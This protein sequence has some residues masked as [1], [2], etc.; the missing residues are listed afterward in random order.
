MSKLKIN[1]EWIDPGGAQGPELSATWARFQLSVD[2]EPVTR[3]LDSVSKTVRDSVFLPIYP[4][5]EWCA[6]HW[7]FLLNEVETPGRTAEVKYPLRHNMYYAS[8][9]FALPPITFR[10]LGNIIKVDWKP[11][12]LPHHRV[13]FVGEGTKYVDSEEFKN[14]ISD[15]ISSVIHRLIEFNCIETLLQQEWQAI[16]EADPEEREFCEASAA[17]GLDPYSLQRNAEQIILN[18]GDTLPKSLIN[19]FFSAADFPHLREQAENVRQALELSRSNTVDLEPLKLLREKAPAYIEM[20][21]APWVQGYQAARQLRRYLQLNGQ[22]LTSFNR[23]G[24]ALSVD[25]D[26][27]R[28]AINPHFEHSDTID[29]VVGENEAGS[30]GFVIS[31]RREE[32]LKFAFC[33]GLFEFLRSRPREPQLVTKTRSE[34]QKRNRAFASEFLVPAEILRTRIQTEYVGEEH[35]DDLAAEFGVSPYVVRYQLHNHHIAQTIP[36]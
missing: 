33:R 29:A 19:E 13:E 24:E 35:V 30:P 25:S 21:G 23:I 34:R 15:F 28:E 22:L 11:A 1:F 7:W 31:N 36:V 4:L 9:G 3:M 12:V 18:I 20:T 17:L 10:P 32:A 14:V 5:A 16:L 27:L 2:G 8:E 26:L 6:T